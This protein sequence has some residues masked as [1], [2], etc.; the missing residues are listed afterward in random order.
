M[1]GKQSGWGCAL[2]VCEGYRCLLLTRFKNKKNKKKKKPSTSVLKG[3]HVSRLPCMCGVT[4]PP[5]LCK[6]DFEPGVCF[7]FF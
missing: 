5:F 6:L 2:A 1:C 3:F 4:N 7:F